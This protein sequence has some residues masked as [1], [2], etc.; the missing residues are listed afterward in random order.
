[1]SHQLK[2][3]CPIC[4]YPRLT[5]FSH[6]LT[7][8]HGISGKERKALLRRARFSVLSMQPDQSQPQSD[9]TPALYVSSLPKSSSLS[10]QKKLSNPIS[11]ENEDELIP[12][13]YDISISYDRVWG[14][15][16]PVMDYDIF[17][18][19]TPLVC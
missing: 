1:M 5:D 13:P 17:N 15:S 4:N 18:C 16:V 14:T 9:S 10:E 2:L 19:T 3:N 6:H 7:T 12:C 11:D 8:V